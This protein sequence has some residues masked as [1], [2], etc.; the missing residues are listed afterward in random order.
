MKDDGHSMPCRSTFAIVPG[1]AAKI[2]S[3]TLVAALVGA[4]GTRYA[5]PTISADEMEAARRSI[6]VT[7]PLVSNERSTQASAVMLD[8]VVQRMTAAAQPLCA[9]YL[10]APCKF[11]VA[12]DPS[13]VPSAEAYSQ[14]R[15]TVSAGMMNILDNEDEIAAVVGHEFGH[16]L[17][18]HIGHRVARAMAA[19]AAASA[20]LGV[21]VPF[22]GVAAWMLGQGAAELGASVARLTFSKEEER[23]ADYLDAYLVARAGY[24]LDRAGR[25]W[26]KL[27]Q[28]SPQESTGLLDSHPVGPERLAA[29]QR[30]TNEIRASSDLVP[31]QRGS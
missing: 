19:G 31:R 15:I 9:A 1:R 3:V 22:G 8:S 26:V 5:L 21:V 11:Q 7:L 6:G 14:E 13:M 27:A 30:A 18:G 24:D 16:H 28:N 2:L 23:E 25:L 12:L 29:W 17:A 4:C 20:V 10:H